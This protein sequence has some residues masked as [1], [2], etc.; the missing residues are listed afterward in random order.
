MK[1]STYSRISIHSIK[2]WRISGA[3]F[4][5]IV[6]GATFA[7]YHFLYQSYMIFLVPAIVG[8]LYI[9]LFPVLEFQQWMYRIDS[10]RVETIH[11]IF[12]VEHSVIP[13][14]RIQHLK[15]VQGILQ[16]GFGIANINIYTAAGVQKI[17]SIPQKDAKSVIDKL[18]ST[19]IAEDVSK[20]D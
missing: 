5:A 6:T 9:F 8:I 19:I 11:G 17:V 15:I 7:V 10:D 1:E 13:I 2:C 14:N 4:T 16:K 12:F 3:I 18:N 20:D